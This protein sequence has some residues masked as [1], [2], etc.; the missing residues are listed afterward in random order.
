MY[1]KLIKVAAFKYEDVWQLKRRIELI[2]GVPAVT[3][4]IYYH[5]EEL[6]NSINLAHLQ[7]NEVLF[8]KTLENNNI[9]K[10]PYYVQFKGSKQTTN[11]DIFCQLESDI[12]VTLKS[13]R[14]L[15]DSLSG[16]K[17]E[18]NLSI[19]GMRIMDEDMI[20]DDSIFKGEIFD[21]EYNL[22]LEEA[23]RQMERLD[24]PA[25]KNKYTINSNNITNNSEPKYNNS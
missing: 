21:V 10:V 9:Y 1:D 14:E 24:P 12:H 4:V 15:Q 19:K 20:I 8:M 23:R 6:T 18:R 25:D 13:F 11:A 3:Q 5:G 2:E 7:N 16:I 17:L 22:N